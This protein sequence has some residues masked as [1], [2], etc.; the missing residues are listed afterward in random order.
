M[1][2]DRGSWI[3]DGHPQR[4]ILMRA[5]HLLSRSLV[6]AVLL[7]A[8]AGTSSAD[9]FKIEKG[10]V[11]MFNG[12][13]LQGWQFSGQ[14]WGLP[15]ESPK[16]GWSVADGVI[17]LD[18]KS[19]GNL[20]SQWSYVD[21]D[22]RFEWRALR[23]KYNSGFFIGSGRKVRANQ[24]NLA[25]G[26]EGRF[27]G[28]KMKGGPAVPD[29]QNASGEW[30]AWRVVVVGDKVT[31]YCNDKLAWEG[32][33]FAA[34]SG[35]IGLQAEGAPLEFRRLRVKEL[36]YDS[37]NTPKD[38]ASADGWK[39]SGDGLTS[40]GTAKGLVS[41]KRATG[42]VTLRFEWKSSK[43][44]AGVVAVGDTRVKLDSIPDAANPAGLWNYAELIR[45][46]GKT[47]YVLNGKTAEI[48]TDSAGT[49]S[50]QDGGK[51]LSLRNIR[52]TSASK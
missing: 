19:R 18:G 24:L 40:D 7:T 16:N 31:F 43:Q 6:I 2:E 34:T 12:A 38:W 29:L 27:F 30:N 15:P 35:Y 51:P 13:D 39:I 23:E 25:K 37:L 9:E 26:G 41:G 3:V 47:T 1:M 32:T 17:K 20:G 22:M 11:S 36:G 8:L 10:F 33:E 49:V 45:V 14:S 50:I 21:F 46:D 28:G 44:S 42:D 5:L 48:K 4:G 52:I